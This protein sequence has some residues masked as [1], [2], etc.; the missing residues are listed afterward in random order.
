MKWNG[1]N[2]WSHYNDVIIMTHVIGMHARF[3]VQ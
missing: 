3:V 1:I 2:E